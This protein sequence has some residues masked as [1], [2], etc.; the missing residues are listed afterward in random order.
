[1]FH[2]K[3]PLHRCWQK[4]LINSPFAENNFLEET[5]HI[6]INIIYQCNLITTSR[7]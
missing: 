3:E 5:T 4:L 2:W 6:R 7:V 1:M